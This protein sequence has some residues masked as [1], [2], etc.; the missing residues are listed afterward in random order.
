MKKISKI[1][2]IVLVSLA[3]VFGYSQLP[4][5]NGNGGNG[6][7]TNPDSVP[8]DSNMNILFAMAAIVFAVVV[9]KHL[10]KRKLL[11]VK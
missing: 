1:T 10:Q 6:T 7:G 11:F 8:F 2:A 3:P 5:P 9:I 4:G